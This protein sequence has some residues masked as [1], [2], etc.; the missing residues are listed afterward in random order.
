MGYGKKKCAGLY[1]P[2]IQERQLDVKGEVRSDIRTYGFA[3]L[4]EE[5]QFTEQ[6]A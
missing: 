1:W 5:N 6:C 2:S 3:C 4:G